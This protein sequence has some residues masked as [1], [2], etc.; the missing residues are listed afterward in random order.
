MNAAQ[1]LL[2]TPED[3]TLPAKMHRAAMDT[4]NR[5]LAPTPNA[6]TQP[7]APRMYLSPA[8]RKVLGAFT[9]DG[10]TNPV[11]ARR[12]GVSED[13]VK[14]HIKHIMTKARRA[15]GV[16]SSDTTFCRTS[17]A[18]LLLKRRLIVRVCHAPYVHDDDRPGPVDPRTRRKYIEHICDPDSVPLP[19]P[20]GAP[21]PGPTPDAS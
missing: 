15:L 3:R 1:P 21:D 11:I 16:E 18:V 19:H 7:A 6:P 5:H 8:E 2:T 17:L 12:I 10:A 13:T 20:R 14:T 9:H 4:V